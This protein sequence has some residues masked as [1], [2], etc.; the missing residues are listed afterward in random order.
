VTAL[1]ILPGDSLTLVQ[2]DLLELRLDGRDEAGVRIPTS[3][4]PHPLWET[5]DSAV[6]TVSQEG[7]LT[8]SGPGLARV[9]ASIPAP[10]GGTAR[11][12]ASA[13]LVVTP[14]P[15]EGVAAGQETARPAEEHPAPIRPTPTTEAQRPQQRP[16]TPPTQAPVV[17]ELHL[18]P[19]QGELT[20]GE[21]LQLG[22]TDQNG[23]PVAGEFATSDLAVATVSSA[24]LL[25]A[26]GAGQVTVTAT[27]E[28]L[29]TTGTFQVRPLV[30]DPP[31]S[32][33]DSLRQGLA[34]AQE[35]ASL[36]EYDAAYELLDA[37]GGRLREMEGRYA[38][39]SLLP[40]A[41]I[42]YL[43]TFSTVYEGCR[44]F[45]QVME[46]RGVTA[47]P[48]CSPPPTGGGNDAHAS[49]SQGGI[50]PLSGIPGKPPLPA[51]SGAPAL[52]P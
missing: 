19:P 52:H 43:E 39:S 21:A 29:S 18:T 49:P 11:I 6:A 24:G 8:P 25:S 37:V 32:A 28:S 40:P 22:L 51:R 48:T 13:V 50:A 34:Q 46:E 42:E 14:P 38:G 9:V 5:S 20:Q 4:L 16:T 33:L 10:A 7:I 26:A 2:G 36:A 15:G 30:V 3:A 47:L 23:R 45:R 12:S 27:F 35:R 31:S 44:R 17:T 1:A 41:R